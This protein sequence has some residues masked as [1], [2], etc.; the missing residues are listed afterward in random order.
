MWP[1]RKTNKLMPC[2]NSP[3][4]LRIVTLRAST[5]KSCKNE[6][7][8]PKSW[9]GCIKVRYGWVPSQ[10]ICAIEPYHKIQ[11]T[12]NVLRRGLNGSCYTKGSS[13]KSL[14][15]PF[16]KMHYSRREQNDLSRDT[17]RRMRITHL[18]LKPYHKGN[19]DWVLLANTLIG[20]NKH[21]EEMG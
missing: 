15:A 4:L 10:D 20:R 12:L 11:K 2:L 19:K 14:L 3:A 21:S 18:R 13:I 7:L 1:D 6:W 8:M 17:W 16:S 9:Y 5:G